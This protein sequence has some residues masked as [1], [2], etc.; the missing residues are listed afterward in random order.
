MKQPSLKM[1]HWKQILGCNRRSDCNIEEDGHGYTCFSCKR[2]F[3]RGVNAVV[4]A[5]IGELNESLLETTDGQAMAHAYRE[6]S[7]SMK[8]IRKV[9]SSE[10]FPGKAWREAKE[11][12]LHRELCLIV[13]SGVTRYEGAVHLDIDDFPNVDIVADATAMPFRANVFEGAICEVVLEHV[14]EPQKVV[15]E[16]WRVLKPGGQ[17]FFVVPFLFPY[18][19]HPSDFHRW[20]RQGLGQAFS[21]FTDVE[22]GIHAGPCSAMVNLLSEWLYIFTGMQYPKGYVPVK[23]L[24]TLALFPI[25]Y[26]DL[27]V[28]RLPEAHRMA[29]TLYVKATK[30]LERP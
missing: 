29:S 6:P 9:V 19:G 25:K 15:E 8:T 20:S 12:T 5:G 27:W 1:P 24:A 13:G 18:H 23:G 4:H 3:P 16:V 10:F 22:I 14:A 17:C 7:S 11:S 26:L 28:N 2:S 30:P 21:G